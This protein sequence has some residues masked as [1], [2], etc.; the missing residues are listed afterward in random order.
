MAPTLAGRLSYDPPLSG[1]RD[2]LTQRMPL[3][4]VAKCMAIYPEPFWRADGLSGEGTSDVGPV[5]LTFD[6]SPPDGSPGVLL[7][8]LEGRHAR[9]LGRMPAEERRAAVVGC[10]TRLFGPRA[11]QPDAYVERLWAEEEWS[12]GCYGCHLPTGAW[13]NY[14]PALREPI[15][16]LHWAGAE[17]AT[18]W[19]GYMDGAVRSGET[20]AAEV[21]ERLV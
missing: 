21:L 4:T 12:R 3:G 8:F 19:N 17:I 15:G 11:A 7:G 20:A 16:P 10:F 5:R 13:T 2:Q 1:F 6:N 18:V 14:G 9:Q